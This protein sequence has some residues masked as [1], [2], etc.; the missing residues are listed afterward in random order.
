[1]Y[2][3]PLTIVMALSVGLAFGLVSYFTYFKKE[4]P[5]PKKWALGVGGISAFITFL[6]GILSE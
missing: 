1:M 3:L 2:G 6:I 5:N 4:M